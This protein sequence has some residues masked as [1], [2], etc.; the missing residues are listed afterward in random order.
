MSKRRDN[1]EAMLERAGRSGHL[2]WLN[3]ACLHRNEFLIKKNQ[4]LLV[5]YKNNRE[6][7]RK[8]VWDRH[9]EKI[10]HSL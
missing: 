2:K 10:L 4:P 5:V 1:R 8:D 6:L 9:L 7:R 3:M